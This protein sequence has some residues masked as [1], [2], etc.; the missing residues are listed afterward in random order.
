MTRPI[1][2]LAGSGTTDRERPA[3]AVN[4]SPSAPPRD[5]RLPQRIFLLSQAERPEEIK[6]SLLDSA[7]SDGWINLLVNINTAIFVGLI[8]L[9]ADFGALQSLGFLGIQLTFTF[10][11]TVIFLFLQLRRQS[12][13]LVGAGA[14][15][16]LLTLSDFLLMA[17]WG[18]GVLLFLSPLHYDR[19]LLTIVLLTAAGIS[20]A[21]LNAKLL[22]TLIMGRIILFL[23]SLVYYLNVQPP[24]WGLLICTLF[25]ACAVSIG[26]GYAIHVQ[27]LHEANLAFK[28]RETSV[29]LEQQS[30]S[31]ERS[32][33]LEHQAQN[34]ILKETKL[35]E[36]FLHSISHDLNQPL[37]ALGLYLND[38]ENQD[39]PERTRASLVSAGQCLGSARSLIQSV[40]Q[41]AWIEEHLPPPTLTDVALQP[42]IAR[43]VAEAATVAR[44]KGLQLVTIA[45]S[46][47]VR[48]DADFLE[49]VLRNLVHNALQYTATGRV[50]IGVRRRVGAQAEIV[51]ADTGMGISTEDQAH[52]FEAFF[53][54]DTAKSRQAGNVGLGL[55]IVHDLV[56]AMN[57]RIT[58]KSI[59]GRGSMFGVVLPASEN[60]PRPGRAKPV[61]HPEKTDTGK[62]LGRVLLCEDREDYRRTIS[63]MLTDLGYAVDSAATPAE[64]A[65]IDGEALATYHTLILDFDLGNGVTAF[66]ILNRCDPG[67]L[68]AYLI[69][70]QY[71][72]PNT[73]FEIKER[74][75]R[76]LKKP[77]D[78]SDLEITLRVLEK[79][80]HM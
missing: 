77:F 39:L 80:G 46:V 6:K 33:L 21:A 38:L 61:E 18:F 37:G 4:P 59:E 32:L 48:A 36:Q 22:P 40:S 26:I 16:K 11:G 13:R 14:T 73:I 1:A 62:S 53:Q 68:P 60:A 54:T 71:D 75:G 20:S 3:A 41:L 17:S 74:G 76:F 2:P 47:H 78:T 67:R 34:R 9:T 31:L 51:V 23:P 35:R 70:S 19:S 64:L 52:I 69:I 49:R 5:R 42:L 44:S 10:V 63:A 43:L 79:R 56:S 7:V 58:L 8:A 12:N 72:D 24:F 30:F 55:S 65:A 28:L 25:F 15:E 66:D 50:V 27:H 29:L 45:T 57:G